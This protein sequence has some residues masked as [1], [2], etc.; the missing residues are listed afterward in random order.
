MG[1]PRAVFPRSLLQLVDQLVV[2]EPFKSGTHAAGGTYQIQ[3]KA[4]GRGCRP[5]SIFL[6]VLCVY[7]VVKE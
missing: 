5:W 6:F 2:R 7:V 4:L 1:L 3:S